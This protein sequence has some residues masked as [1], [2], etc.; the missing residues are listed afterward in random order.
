[1]SGMILMFGAIG[2]GVLGLIVGAIIRKG[3]GALVG[4]V[5]GAVLGAIGYYL[6]WNFVGS[7][8]FG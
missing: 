5:L 3:K 4:V 2:G 7:S 8:M 6:V 1:M